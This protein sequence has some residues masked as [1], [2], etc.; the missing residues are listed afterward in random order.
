[1]TA[2]DRELLHQTART[3]RAMY[4]ASKTLTANVAELAF[5]NAVLTTACGALFA[6]IARRDGGVGTLDE[7]LA[8]LTASMEDQ[9][10][11]DGHI[12]RTADLIR[13]VAEV[14]IKL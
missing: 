4:E 1:M 9:S 13:Q 11:Q 6:E 14:L 7:M 10:D 3:Q 5:A 8:T 2:E 12:L